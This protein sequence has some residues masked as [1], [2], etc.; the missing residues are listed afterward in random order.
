VQHNNYKSA[1]TSGGA[2]WVIVWYTSKTD[3]NLAERLERKLKNLTRIRK[4]DFMIKYRENVAK[5]WTIADL[6]KLR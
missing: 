6:N 1:Y 4:I 5:E 2:P 3:R